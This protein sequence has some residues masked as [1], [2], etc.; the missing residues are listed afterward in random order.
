M[1]SAQETKIKELLGFRREETYLD[2]THIWLM[3]IDYN[4]N[5][6]FWVSPYATGN[7]PGPEHWEPVLRSNIES[8]LVDE[9]ME[10]LR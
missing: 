9:L 8:E 7:D 2:G 6:L 1:T 4:G 10:H 5:L 3:M